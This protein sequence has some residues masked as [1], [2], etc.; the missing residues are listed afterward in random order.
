MILIVRIYCNVYE[1]YVEVSRICGSPRHSLFYF[2]VDLD[3]FC[4][5]LTIG[6]LPESPYLFYE[7]GTW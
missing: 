1:R 7:G 5:D 2:S 6:H 4:L 3:N